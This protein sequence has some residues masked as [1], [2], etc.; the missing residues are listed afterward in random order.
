MAKPFKFNLEKVLEYRCQ[1]ED[2]AKQEL[3]KAQ[4]EHRAQEQ[5]VQNILTR[6]QEH[7][8]AYFANP[9]LSAEELW[10]WKNFKERLLLDL[11]QARIVLQELALRLE[12]ARLNLVARAKDR[13]LLEKLKENQ[14]E[15]HAREAGLKEQAEFDEMATIR[16]QREDL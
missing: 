2:A 15:K 8:A 3:T 11:S 6:Q 13:K 9:V 7:E 5:L 10:L 14:A 16:H 12:T 1:L 4:L